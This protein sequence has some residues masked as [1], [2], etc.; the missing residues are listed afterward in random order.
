MTW[1]ALVTEAV[2]DPALASP[3]EAARDLEV[4]VSGATSPLEG[5]SL[6][7]RGQGV[8]AADP[9]VAVTF[10]LGRED[11]VMLRRQVLS[12]IREPSLRVRA[13]EVTAVEI[14]ARRHGPPQAPLPSARRTRR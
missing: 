5:D 13:A 12:G 1:S 14:R 8:L 2:P 10:L 3:E 6:F 4:V 11:F 9:S 7:G